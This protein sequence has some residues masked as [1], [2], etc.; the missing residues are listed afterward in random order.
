MAL[1]KQGDMRIAPNPR[2]FPYTDSSLLVW[3]TLI[4]NVAYLPG[5]LTLAYSLKGVASR[6][7][8]VVLYTDSCPESVHVALAQRGIRALR[9]ERLS[10]RKHVEYSNDARFA[11]CWTKLV[12]FD[13]TQFER[14]VLLDSDML[15]MRNMDELMDLELDPSAQEGKGQRVF[16]AAHACVCNPMKK[17]HY[18]K[19][20]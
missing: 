2:G 10:P 3:A 7:E 16:A 14:V 18:P 19:N 8:L 6:Y 15:V 11:E 20:W 13:L 5:V 1:P 12:C 4:T 17:A 9:V